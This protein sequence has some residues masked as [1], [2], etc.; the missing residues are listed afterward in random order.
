MASKE[1]ICPHC[2]KALAPA[3]GFY[4]DADHNMFCGHC[5]GIVFAAVKSQEEK[6]RFALSGGNKQDTTTYHWQKKELLPIKIIP[7]ASQPCPAKP[8][9]SKAGEPTPDCIP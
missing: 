3:G 4:H 9:H 1:L 7:Q 5:N 6:H 8:A 2:K